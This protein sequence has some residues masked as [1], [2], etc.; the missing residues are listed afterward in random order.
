MARGARFEC[1]S[2]AS[3][4]D[5]RVSALPADADPPSP[6]RQPEQVELGGP[7]QLVLAA[8]SRP[9]AQQHAMAEGR[10]E[11]LGAAAAAVEAFVGIDAQPGL[12]AAGLHPPGA[13]RRPVDVRR[14]RRA[15]ATRVHVRLTKD[16]E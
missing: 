3:L 5:R 11:A 8:A 15:A 10:R 9:R 7:A 16:D 2:N 14:Q 1:G 4:A 12:H 6:R 13:L